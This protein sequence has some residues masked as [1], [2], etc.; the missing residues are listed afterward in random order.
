ME[1]PIPDIPLLT[2]REEVELARQIEAGLFAAEALA[3][4]CSPCAASPE[5]LRLLAEQGAAAQ[6][7]LFM[8]NLRLVALHARSWA[9]RSQ[10]NVEDLFQEGC[11]GLAQAVQ[12]WDHARGAKFGTL[13]WRMVGNA[14]L[15]VVLARSSH[16]G[17]TPSRARAVWQVR[18]TQGRLEVELGRAVSVRELADHLGKDA[19]LIAEYLSSA[20]PA[21]LP[22]EL[23]HASRE[24]ELPGFSLGWLAELPA[25]ER[26]I[27]AARYGIGQPACTLDELAAR[28]GT[29][30]TSARRMETKALAAA[31]RVLTHAGAA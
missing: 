26:E 11:V 28:L 18:R 5:E 14:V 23:P 16:A 1:L 25:P 22:T 7:R 24:R 31:R 12:A 9:Q 8:A 30:P 13:A 27:L 15:G 2:V 20:G 10:L 6:Q 17:S 3:S 29:S 4:G 21:R 19:G